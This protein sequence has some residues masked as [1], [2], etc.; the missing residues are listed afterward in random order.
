MA[1]TAKFDRQEVI[2]KATELYWRKGF[3]ATSMRNLQ[4]EIDMRPGSIYA[5]F[6]SKDELFKETL[7]NYTYAALASLK[8]CCELHTTRI[9]ALKSFITTAVIKKEKN[10]PN[11]MCM[12]T[13]TMA[14]LTSEHQD[15]IDVTASFL[16]QIES[17]F[18]GI[19]K[20]AQE[21]GEI[22]MDR[23]AAYLASYV[24]IQIAGL[25]SYAKTNNDKQKLAKMIDDLFIHYPF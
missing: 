11:G 16:G 17:A 15:I 20:E 10:T 1:K 12:L 3:H 18:E 7:R 6:G 9:D 22:P 19:I 13:K 5:A 24:Q 23:D 2:D 4:D 21:A 8:E 14:E 25:R